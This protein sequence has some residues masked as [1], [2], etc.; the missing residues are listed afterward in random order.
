MVFVFAAS[1]QK[2]EEQFDYNFKPTYS[3]ARYYV[4]TEKKDSLYHRTAWYLPEKT[5]AMDGWYRDKEC[6]VPNDT[7]KWFHPNRYLKSTGVYRNGL[8]EGVWMEFNPQGALIDSGYYS[9][10]RLKGIRMKWYPNGYPSDSLQ[11]DG[12][13][14]GVQVSWH[15]NGFLK[16]AGYFASDTLKK[17]RWKY[18]NAKGNLIAAVEYFD[19][20]ATSCY[21]ESGKQL[22]NC[23]EV[24]AIPAGGMQGWR[25]YMERHLDKN[26]PMRNGAPEGLYTVQVRFI[27]E[28]DGTLSNFQPLTHLGYGMEEEVM[29]VFKNAPKWTP[30]YEFGQP[31]RSY[32]TQPVSFAISATTR[33]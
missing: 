5:L 20:K 22:P 13:G 29:R 28:A 27:V 23:E 17:G 7:L 21:D 18:Y 24:E 31:V 9:H 14:N 15:S 8:K 33:Y 3:L 16:S 6:K 32:H 11:F 30:G 25:Q 26:V 2:K 4:I 12:E 1:G 19:G 10:G